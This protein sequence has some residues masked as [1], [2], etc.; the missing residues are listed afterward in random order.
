[1]LFNGSNQHPMLRV[2]LPLHT[3]RC[4]IL[5]LSN[6]GFSLSVV[7][8]VEGHVVQ[9]CFKVCACAKGLQACPLSATF[10]WKLGFTSIAQKG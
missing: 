4:T 5:Y 7:I 10:L 9:N 1:M 8:L 3:T 6:L 2:C